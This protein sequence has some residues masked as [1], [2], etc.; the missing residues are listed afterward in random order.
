MRHIK[1]HDICCT[2]CLSIRLCTMSLSPQTG[3]SSASWGS[4]RYSQSF[5][6]WRASVNLPEKSRASSSLCCLRKSKPETRWVHFQFQDLF[7]FFFNAWKKFEPCPYRMYRTSP[8]TCRWWCPTCLWVQPSDFPGAVCHGR[9]ELSREGCV[10]SSMWRR[11]WA[12]SIAAVSGTPDKWLRDQLVHSFTFGCEES[13][14][15]C[16]PTAPS[17]QSAVVW[18]PRGTR[19]SLYVCLKSVPPP[20][21]SPATGA[22]TH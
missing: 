22:M 20:S 5:R 16:R 1:L 7:L 14:I 11:T 17:V 2:L 15:R 21:S 9:S 6:A 12:A 13:C 8:W 3:T 10:R 4:A 19:Q 18:F